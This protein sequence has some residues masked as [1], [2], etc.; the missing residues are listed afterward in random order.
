[1][2]DTKE[3]KRFIQYAA[4]QLGLKKIPDIHFVGHE[5]DKNKA[6]GHFQHSDDAIKVRTVD[7]HPLDV[8]RTIAHEMSHYKW[9][10]EGE[11]GDN[12]PGGKSE[13]YAH[14]RAGEIMRNY[15]NSHPNMF[16]DKPIKEDGAFAGVATN[17]MGDSSSKAGTG[18]IDTVDKF[19]GNKK[20]K[21]LSEIITRKTLGEVRVPRS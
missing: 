21:K 9:R 6:F 18:A 14:A 20:K 11:I 3:L 16:K 17:A 10:L 15:D 13:N 5:E 1:M 7:R 8:M 2:N 12:V 19:L 4:K